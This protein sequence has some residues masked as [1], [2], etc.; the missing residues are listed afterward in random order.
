M[1]YG[2]Y[3]KPKRNKKPITEQQALL[4]LT[5][6]CTQ[7]E[8]CSQEMLDKMRKWEL[9]EEAIARNMEFLTQKKFIDDERYARAFINDKVKYNKW[10]RRKVEQALWMKHISK[11]ISAPIFAEMED[12]LYTD[13]LL[14]LMISKYKSI[15]A[16]NDYER[17]MKL[18][19]FA[20][21]RGYDMDIIKK[22]LDRMKEEDLCIADEDDFSA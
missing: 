6:L 13:T 22:C 20:M 14:P 10:G 1:E 17:S 9:P 4:K 19:R 12:D 8:H 21:G 3:Q 2:S 7:S 16:K 15:K 11:D 18:I 5:T